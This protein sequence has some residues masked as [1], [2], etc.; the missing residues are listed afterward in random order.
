MVAER[1]LDSIMVLIIPCLYRVL[2]FTW[3]IHLFCLIPV[4]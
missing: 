2:Y 4:V 3:N 1:C